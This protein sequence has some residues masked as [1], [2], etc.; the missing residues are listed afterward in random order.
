LAAAAAAADWLNTTDTGKTT[1]LDRDEWSFV[2]VILNKYLIAVY[3]MVG[4][5]VLV[6]SI[7]YWKNSRR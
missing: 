6:S 2:D 7:M 3:I 1:A 5:I 4:F